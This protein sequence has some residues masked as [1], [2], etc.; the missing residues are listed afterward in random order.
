MNKK[1]FL[2]ILIPAL[3]L[4]GGYI[5]IRYSLK[6]SITREGGKIAT[7]STATKQSLS[8]DLRPL[9]IQR[10]KQLVAK[11]SNNIYDLSVG[12]MKADILSS[13]AVFRMLF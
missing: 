8:P 6:A 13:T 3:L 4:I 7:D 1:L 9:I 5:F 10:L 2:L 12:N 11:T